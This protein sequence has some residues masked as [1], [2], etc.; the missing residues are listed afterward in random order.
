MHDMHDHSA[1]TPNA[2]KQKFWGSVLLT[3]PV[4]LFSGTIQQWLHYSLT[5]SG[6]EFVPA[7]FGVILFIYGGWVFITGAKDELVNK[8]PG[9]MTL[10]AMA[11]SVAFIYSIAVTFGAVHGMD[12][13]WELATLIDIMLLGHW[14][15]MSSISKAG[16]ALH[17]LAA[18]LPDQA[19]V[20][21]G[22][23]TKKVAIH[24][25]QIGDVVRIR[26]GASVPADA[27]VVNGSSE[28]DE[29]M[30]TGESRPI[31][32]NKGDELI[33]G[34]INTGDGAITA[35]VTKIGDQTM[36]AGI[37]RLV[38]EAEQSKGKSQRLA[39]T[40]A[41]YL[42]YIALS[43]AALTLIGWVIVGGRT[44]DFVLERVVTVLII[45][46]P[47]ALGLAIPLVVAIATSRAARHGFLI[48][49]QAAFETARQVDV[50]VFDKTGTLTTGQQMVNA[51]IARDNQHVLSV[52]ASVELLSEHS[53]GK[54]IVAEAKKRKTATSYAENFAIIKGRGA[55]AL[56]NKKHIIVGTKKLL[57][58]KGIDVPESDDVASE[59]HV[60]N[61]VI[62][63][64]ED[65]KYIG[66]ISLMD[67]IRSESHAAVKRL[68]QNGIKVIMLTGDGDEVA[69]RVAEQL[70][71]KTYYAQVL[72][73]GKI[74]LIKKLQSQ[75]HIVA[76]VGDGVNDAAAL[77]Q[78]NVG[79][80]MGAGTNVAIES[81]DIVLVTSDPRAVMRS[82]VL[83]RAT[84]RKMQ[85]NLVWA[86]GY[87]AVTLP[88][89]TGITAGAG[90]I[91]SPAV[92][93]VMMSLSTMIVALNAQLLRRVRL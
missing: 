40:I 68:Q 56:V 92:G 21:Q 79:I 11:M 51:V 8:Q 64:A 27:I 66:T 87:N 83:A 31:V 18:L 48:R 76:M 29:S 34:T 93:A 39:D 15:E 17:E 71:I 90:F 22:S 61:T 53:I 69:A 23:A 89:A 82:L 41:A 65:K 28:I 10:I 25:L 6:S 2:F 44:T 43:V 45:A 80:A 85:Q 12:F 37:M 16:S 57:K 91:L 58:I 86:I 59:L 49:K 46:C 88:L 35:M 55:E 75:H 36:L 52:A 74:D 33:A 77:A 70:G 38:K 26:P 14:I 63:V 13:W 4:L 72:P 19:E 67:G 84:Y 32:K 3:L 9:M 7:I 30:V 24:M 54:A 42:F 20:V 73:A 50:V 60:G 1:H 47:H 78:A 81:A 5:F 62:Y